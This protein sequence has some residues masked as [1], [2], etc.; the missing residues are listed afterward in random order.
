MDNIETKKFVWAYLLENGKET[1]G[2][3]SYYGSEWDSIRGRK[4]DHDYHADLLQLIKTVG[5][6][7]DKT[8]E[9]T[10]GTEI[11]F[12]GTFVDSSECETLIGTLVLKNGNEVL[13]GCRDQDNIGSYINNLMK[14]MRD[15]NRVKNI[16]GE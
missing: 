12:D 3:W 7:W 14:L 1:T 2:K 15:K 9:P 13:V 5:V 4:W 10:S 8:Q 16:F 6:D 11:C